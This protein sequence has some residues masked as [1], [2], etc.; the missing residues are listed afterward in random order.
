VAG[1]GSVHVVVGAGVVDV[2]ARCF[3]LICGKKENFF[4]ITHALRVFC[5]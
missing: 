3:F 2:I 5:F 4:F 1:L